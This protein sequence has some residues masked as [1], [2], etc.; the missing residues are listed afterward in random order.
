MNKEQR[1]VV[2]TGKE[3]LVRHLS[4][5]SQENGE[6]TDIIESDNTED[7]DAV[8]EILIGDVVYRKVCSRTAN[9]TEIDNVTLDNII[10]NIKGLEDENSLLRE[11]LKLEKERFTAENIEKFLVEQQLEEQKRQMSDLKNDM[12]DRVKHLSN[13]SGEKCFGFDG[14]E[15]QPRFRVKSLL[16]EIVFEEEEA[17]AAL[18]SVRKQSRRRDLLE[19][20]I[21][22]EQTNG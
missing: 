5:K 14:V 10:D 17:V 12:R 8:Q 16:D 2:M 22:K 20:L 6:G 13:S 9:T 1:K 21:C 7:F 15:I 18:E 3:T 4:V 11:K 19:K